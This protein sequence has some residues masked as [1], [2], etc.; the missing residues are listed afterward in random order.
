MLNQRQT[1]GPEVCLHPSR[2]H[3][4]PMADQRLLFVQHT[5]L[6]QLYS[7]VASGQVDL[8]RAH[9][10]SSSPPFMTER[11]HQSGTS[12]PLAKCSRAG[13]TLA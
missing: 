8:L 12:N 5:I 1:S 9:V 6:C 2:T 3:V 7:A 10:V 4:L 11:T 13:H